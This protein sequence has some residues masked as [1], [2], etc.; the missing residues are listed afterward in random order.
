MCHV[1]KHSCRII[2]VY[3]RLKIQAKKQREKKHK[4]IMLHY[5]KMWIYQ[6]TTL[7]KILKKIS[8]K[9]D[10][11]IFSKYLCLCVFDKNLNTWLLQN[12]LKEYSNKN[13]EFNFYL[14]FIMF[15]F[16]WIGMA[17][18]FQVGTGKLCRNYTTKLRYFKGTLWCSCYDEVV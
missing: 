18:M 13:I 15:I 17:F 9:I 6:N 4:H 14:F 3:F 16:L 8:S 2:N 1:F 7:T 11:S 10:T 5:L 12:Q